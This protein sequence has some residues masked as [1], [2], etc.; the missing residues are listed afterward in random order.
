MYKGPTNPIS[1]DQ[2]K[3]K[4][5]INA[6]E[7]FDQCVKR[8]AGGLSDDSQH[9]HAFRD[10]L[11]NQRFLPAGRVQRAIGGPRRV[12]AYNCFVS[13]TIK[14]TSND[15]LTKVKEA[16][17]TMRQGGGIGYDFSTIRPR[18]AE[19]TTLGS[20][21][22]GPVSFMQ[23]FDASCKT[24]QSAGGRRGAQMAV[25]RVDHPDVEEFIKSKTE[26]NPDDMRA[27]GYLTSDPNAL[28]VA[29]RISLRTQLS[30]FNVSV[31]V[32]DE[33]MKALKNDTEYDLKFEGKVYDRKRALDVWNMVMESTWDW[34][35]P[36]ILFIDRI[37]QM[38]NL[39]YCE[40]IAATNPCGEQPLPPYGACLLGSFALPKYITTVN[41]ERMINSALLLNDVE[42]VVRAMDNIINVASYPLD[43]QRDEAVSKRR[44]GLGVTGLANA[45]ESMGY[46]Y[47][48]EAFNEVTYS[49]LSSITNALYEASARLAK[50][51]GPF[52]L[53]D[54]ERYLKSNFI[55]SGILTESTISAISEYGIRNSHLTS[56]APTGTISLTADNMSSGIEPVFAYKTQREIKDQNN[57]SDFYEINDY[58][59]ET[60]NVYGRKADD[61]SVQEHV[62]VLAV[63]QSTVDSAVSKTCNVGDNVTFEEFKEVYMSAYDLGCKGCTTF[64]A[65]G[66]RF[67][68]LKSLDEGEACTFDPETGAK[69]CG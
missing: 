8:I 66:K 36:G 54:K 44:M 4:Y 59:V 16:F 53:Y 25:L 7:T 65:A 9:E 13:G 41:G 60:F 42:H 1:I 10:I 47:G 24:V 51:K 40:E 67:G 20:G 63:A 34:A 6:E 3:Q 27:A 62:N 19:I 58:G 61:I 32:T 55:N 68:V 5:R 37:N 28:E 17:L 14:D 21:S 31:G 49:L 45:L 69:S 38:N 11:G 46:P 29:K 64:R 15:I 2:H 18:G 22:S 56:I 35:E 30:A 57:V 50:E 12:T 48:T 23:I 26:P 33:F 43:E 39:W 52:K